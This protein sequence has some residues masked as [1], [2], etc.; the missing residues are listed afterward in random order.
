MSRGSQQSDAA[1]ALAAKASDA[2]EAVETCAAKGCEVRPRKHCPRC[3]GKG[4]HSIEVGI[5]ARRKY[6][7]WMKG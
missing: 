2:T 3:R 7:S 4:R 6:Q 5:A 1:L